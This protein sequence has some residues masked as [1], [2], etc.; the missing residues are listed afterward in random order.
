MGRELDRRDFSVSKATL[1]R[2]QELDARAAIVMDQQG[3]FGRSIP[4]F[5]VEKLDPTTGNAAVIHFERQPGAVGLT[6]A[7]RFVQRA[8]EAVQTISPSLGLAPGQPAEFM[9][10]PHVQEVRSGARAVH[11]HQQYKSITLFQATEAVRFAPNGELTTVIGSI[12]TV[13]QDA[14]PAPRLSMEEATRKAAEFVAVPEADELE[15]HDQFGQS[16]QPRGVDLAGFEPRRLTTFENQPEQLSL[17]EGGPF[18]GQIRANLIWFPLSNGILRLAWEVLLAMPDYEAQFRI[19]VDSENGDI[20]YAR[21]LVQNV[22]ARGNVYTVNGDQPRQMV[23]F[24]LSVQTYG[25]PIPPDVQSGFPLDWV[26]ADSTVGN[27]VFAHLGESQRT[28]RGT[29]Q[30]SVLTFSP[31]DLG[32]DDQ[33]ILNIFFHNCIMHDFFYLLGFREENGNFQHSNIRPDRTSGGGAA[34][35]RVDARVYPGPVAMTASMFT[36]VDG[37]SPIMK[38]GLVPDKGRHTAFDA[39]VIYHEF[40]HGVTNRLVGG[41]LNVHA[42]EAPQCR[43]MGEGWGDY[44]ACT[45]TGSPVIAAW[46]VNNPGGIRQ[47]RYDGNFPAQTEHFGR[48][49]QGRYREEHN[50]GEIWCATLMEMNRNIGVTLGLQLV[51]DALKLSPANPSFLDA[52]DA[53]LAALD[54]EREANVMSPSEY[55]RA[56][57]GIWKAFAKFGMGPSARS[58]GPFLEGIAPDFNLPEGVIDTMTSGTMQP[59]TRVETPANMSLHIPDAEPQGVTSTL[60]FPHLGRIAQLT[61]SIDIEHPVV[62]DLRVSLTSPAGKTVVLHDHVQGAANLVKAYTSQETPALATLVSEQA[63]GDWTLTVADL[64]KK[65]IGRLRSWA[66]EIGV[67]SAAEVI[68]GD[69]APGLAIADAPST[70][71]ESR[72]AIA[73]SG[74][75]GTIKVGID[76]THPVPSDLIVQLV[77]PSGRLAVLHDRLATGQENLVTTYESRSTPALSALINEP[78]QGNWA[79]RVMDMERKDTGVLNRWSLELNLAGGASSAGLTGEAIAINITE[80]ANTLQLRLQFPDERTRENFKIV[81]QGWFQ[82]YQRQAQ[83]LAAFERGTHDAFDYLV[84][85]GYHHS[86]TEG[87]GHLAQGLSH[88]PLP[89]E[90]ASYYVNFIAGW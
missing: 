78:I 88:L 31:A 22:R 61:V 39:S 37:S 6:A 8:L 38:M 44:I 73:Q 4:P 74:T 85:H 83:L 51:V 46:V 12:I 48:L 34:S 86:T 84:Q 64:E 2:K 10:D 89:W 67:E 28:L 43:G 23:D 16:H 25:L 9:A 55:T 19:L 50:I 82:Q 40:T 63:E 3:L 69:V 42:L 13:D 41:P 18:E 77:A 1:A 20:L 75:A 80:L 66:L 53:I 62:A 76:I 90:M 54:F 24:P 21:Q 27:A 58:N 33:K 5:T 14:A 49:G 60:N 57:L 36:P 70:G 56:R 45:V 15:A 65:D 32:S 26:E 47:F 87:S 17:L 11:L 59:G 29:V 7:D 72:I 30:N 79:L 68:R 81:F 71:V 35:D 52:R